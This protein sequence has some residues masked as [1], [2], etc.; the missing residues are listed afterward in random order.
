M[1]TVSVF[2]TLSEHLLL[3]F[4]SIC[5][6]KYGS[7]VAE[8]LIKTLSARSKLDAAAY[9]L[10]TQPYFYGL[11]I[12]Q[13]G[14]FVVEKIAEVATGEVKTCCLRIVKYVISLFAPAASLTKRQS[15]W[16]LLSRLPLI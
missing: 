8:C 5:G 14:C 15:Y 9:W 13:H 7:H 4:Q 16:V 12:D 2:D 11:I 6:C 1:P 3:S 10:F